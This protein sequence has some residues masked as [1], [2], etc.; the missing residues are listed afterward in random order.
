M[1]SL[2]FPHHG[3]PKQHENLA[4]APFCKPTKNVLKNAQKYGLPA[5]SLA[6]QRF[7]G[8]Q[9]RLQQA[10]LFQFQQ[11]LIDAHNV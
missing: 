1:D 5:P 8:W 9:Q 3:P 11:N 2:T 6:C 7:T 4:E 10:T